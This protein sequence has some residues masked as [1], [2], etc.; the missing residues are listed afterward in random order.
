MK[1]VLSFPSAAT[2]QLP[3]KVKLPKSL[4]QRIADTGAASVTQAA[5][6]MSQLRMPLA[7]SGL[8]GKHF[9]KVAHA[10]TKSKLSAVLPF[11]A[12]AAPSTRANPAGIKPG[13]NFAAALSYGDVTFAGI[14]TTTAVCHGVALAFGH[15]FTFGG[16]VGLSAHTANALYIQPDSLFGPFKVANLGGVAGTVDQDRLAAIRA[17]L[18]AGPVPIKVTSTVSA[19]GTG[20]T[21]NG[22]TFV[23]QDADLPFIAAIH[24]L[25]NFDRTFQKIGEGTSLVTWTVTG[26]TSAGQSFTLTRTNR[27]ASQ[28]DVSFESIFEMLRFL[29]EIQGQSFVD[30]HFSKVTIKASENEVFRQYQ[31]DKVLRKTGKNTYVPVN[32]RTALRVRAGSRV[33]LRVHLVPYRNRGVARNFDFT[34]RIPANRAGSSG[35]LRVIGGGRSGF[36]GFF[37]GECGGNGAKSF[38]DVLKSLSSQPRNDQLTATMIIGPARGKPGSRPA[39]TNLVRT[40]N[41]VV[42]GFRFIRVIVTR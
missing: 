17:S 29:S 37:C 11:R 7:I 12:G 5:G 21:R 9:N 28:Y 30:V 15:P 13:G 14:G 42:T 22:T 41:Q 40:A 4:Q 24:L 1:K 19:P 36:F 35:F 2:P 39:V 33:K 6:G 25:S 38:S 18:G 26:K 8:A 23:N 27:F 31:I 10:I 34:Y 16:K 3:A 20:L 32:S